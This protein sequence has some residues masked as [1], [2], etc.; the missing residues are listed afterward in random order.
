MALVLSLK[1]L[2]GSLGTDAGTM[3]LLLTAPGII[4]VLLVLN[5]TETLQWSTCRLG[6]T[7]PNGKKSDHVVSPKP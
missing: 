2:G 5:T 4:A 7:N 3:L 1:G 6:L